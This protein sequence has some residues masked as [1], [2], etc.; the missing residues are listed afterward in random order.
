MAAMPTEDEAASSKRTRT[1]TVEYGSSCWDT[2]AVLRNRQSQVN[3]AK[4]AE[5]IIR[6]G[7]L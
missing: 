6:A 7:G 2:A 4:A 3:R 5:S 1:S